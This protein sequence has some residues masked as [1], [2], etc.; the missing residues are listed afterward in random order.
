MKTIKPILLI[1]VVLMCT[2]SFGQDNEGQERIKTLKIAHLTNKLALTPEEAQK[3]WPIYNVHET[4]M[5]TFKKTEKTIDLRKKMQNVDDL[6]ETE[7]ASIIEKLSAL[8]EKREKEKA[9][10]IAS[11]RKEF[12]AKK[13]LQLMAAEASF[14]RNMLHRY[15]SRF[16][17]RREAKKNAYEERRDKLMDER[18]EKIKERKKRK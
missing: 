4:K 1:L 5:K 15:K 13:A 16:D 6:N 7:A 17:E 3:F 11:I 9:N 10:F 8:N 2:I 18:S 14:K 12:S